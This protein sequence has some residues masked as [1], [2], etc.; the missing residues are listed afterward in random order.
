MGFIDRNDHSCDILRQE[1]D[2][3]QGQRVHPPEYAHQRKHD[4]KGRA[5][6][7]VDFQSFEPFSLI[8]IVIILHL[9]LPQKVILVL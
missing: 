4:H 5:N 1:N 7:D 8:S 3:D 9:F 6:N 2:P